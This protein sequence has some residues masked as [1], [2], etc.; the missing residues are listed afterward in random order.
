MSDISG[1]RLGTIQDQKSASCAQLEPTVMKKIH[2]NWDVLPVFVDSPL[3]KK[4]APAAHSVS[5]VRIFILDTIFI[6]T[7]SEKTIRGPVI[8][9]NSWKA[10][11]N[12][13]PEQIAD[14]I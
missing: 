14:K 13:F 1:D 2:L 11:F 8:C 10:E 5:Q 6:L 3:N 9:I 12:T 4:E 7:S